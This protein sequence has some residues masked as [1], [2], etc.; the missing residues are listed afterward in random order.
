MESIIYDLL[1]AGKENA[2]PLKD[3]RNLF[4]EWSER[5]VL[6]QI[7]RERKAGYPILNLRVKG[8]GYFTSD[9]P[10]DIKDCLAV[11]GQAIQSQQ[12]VYNGIASNL[13]EGEKNKLF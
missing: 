8:G 2:L 10:E 4:P 7:E 13:N 9:D 12:Q 5:D 3:L 6:K 1:S 11:L